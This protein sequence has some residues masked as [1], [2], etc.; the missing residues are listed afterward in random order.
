MLKRAILL[1]TSNERECEMKRFKDLVVISSHELTAEFW[2]THNGAHGRDIISLVSD[3][4]SSGAISEVVENGVEGL[5]TTVY[6]PDDS[7]S[8]E[9]EYISWTE[10]TD[11]RLLNIQALDI[12]LLCGVTNR[13][14]ESN[15][16]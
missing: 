4:I 11:N 5:N 6:T 7:Q 13:E 15:A 10:D 16:F 12:T 9:F 8:V 14:L 2:V 3:Q 1:C